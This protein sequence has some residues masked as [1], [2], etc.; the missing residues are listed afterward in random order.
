[1]QLVERKR[2]RRRIWRNEVIEELAILADLSRRIVDAQ[3][4]GVKRPVV[5]RALVCKI[6]GSLRV[7]RH[8]RSGCFSLAVAHAFVVQEKKRLVL[9]DRAAKCPTKL[10]PVKWLYAVGEEAL[11]IHGIVPQKFPRRTVK[12]VCPRARHYACRR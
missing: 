6:P 4:L 9:L 7:G 1:G 11:R 8:R 5:Q 12:T 2:L 10:V 3:P